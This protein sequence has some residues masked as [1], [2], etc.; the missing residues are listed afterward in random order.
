MATYFTI[1]GAC[2]VLNAVHVLIVGEPF[3]ISIG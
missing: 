3:M 2:L 1:L